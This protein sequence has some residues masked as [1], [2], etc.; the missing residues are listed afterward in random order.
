MVTG[1][2]TLLLLRGE[3][4]HAA[5]RRARLTE[6]EIRAAV[7][8]HGLPAIEEVEAVVLE[9]DGS[10]SVIGAKSGHPPSS[11]AGIEMPH[12]NNRHQ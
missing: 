9:T 11:L 3:Y 7:R 8:S 6:Q 2:P 10:F 4:L 5:L 12:Q 1:E